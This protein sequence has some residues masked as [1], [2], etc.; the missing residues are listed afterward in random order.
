MLQV[1]KATNGTFIGRVV[2]DV[3][4]ISGAVGLGQMLAFAAAPLLTRLYSPEAFGH[5]AILNALINILL[6]LISLRLNWALPLPRREATARSLLVLCMLV[7]AVSA[8]LI[9]LL[10]TLLHPMLTG[11]IDIS[12]TDIWLLTAA[13]LVTGLHEV[14]LSWLVRLRAF[15]Q[16]AGVRFITLVGVVGCQIVFAAR[17]PDASSLLLGYIGGYGLGVIRAVYHCRATVLESLRGVNPRHMRRLAARYRRFP[18]VATPSSIISGVSAQVPSLALPALYGFAMAGQWSLAGRVLWQ[19]TA[20]IGQAV[21]QV[22]WGNAAR[23]QREDPKRLWLLFLFL[24]GSLL[25]LMAPALTLNWFGPALFSLVFGPAWEPA[26]HFAGIMVLSSVL[27]LASHGTESLHIYGLN[28]WMAGWEIARLVFIGCALASAWQLEL[29][30]TG[31]V[32]A[33]T[34]A[35]V[36]TYAALIALN[37]LAIRRL[38]TRQ[39]PARAHTVPAAE[40]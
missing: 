37:A 17:L 27:G 9:A 19:P 1:N 3:M 35:Y 23:L 5:F 12:V 29:S 21:G 33:L 6:P 32:I 24:N 18:L 20:L 7:T 31:C 28:H 36:V 14:S 39:I 13:L 11:W 2:G 10:G 22:F 40:G 4:R 34:V 8:P 38:Q 16:V 30:A 26:G 15:S 25:A